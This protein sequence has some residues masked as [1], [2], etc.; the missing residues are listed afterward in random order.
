MLARRNHVIKWIL[1][2][3][4]QSEIF[5]QSYQKSFTIAEGNWNIRMI[6]FCITAGV[7]INAIRDGKT[8]LDS[9]AEQKEIPLVAPWTFMLQHG[10]QHA[11]F[12]HVSG[13]GQR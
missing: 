7:D 1:L 10:I 3:I 9:I 12:P 4:Y 6:D 8:I 13:F 5:A 2:G 11:A